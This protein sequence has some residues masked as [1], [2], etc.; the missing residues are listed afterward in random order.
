MSY[1]S[2]LI[3]MALDLRTK[4]VVSRESRTTVPSAVISSHDGQ[5]V[6]VRPGTFGWKGRLVVRRSELH[7][8]RVVRVCGEKGNDYVVLAGGKRVLMA[9]QMVGR[10]DCRPLAAGM[11]REIT[12]F[13]NATADLIAAADALDCGEEE[14]DSEEGGRMGD[15]GSEEEEEEEDAIC[16]VDMH[17]Y[18]TMFMDNVTWQ[19]EACQVMTLILGQA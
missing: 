18:S 17:R 16:S 7:G 1:D 3:N 2:P 5:T 9:S 14:E 6:V 4:I 8:E 13:Y 19:F 11:M 15:V 10:W 12:V